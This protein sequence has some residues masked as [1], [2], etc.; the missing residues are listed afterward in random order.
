[1]D[2]RGTTAARAETQ[3]IFE[4]VAKRR[5]DICSRAESLIAGPLQS[6]HPVAIVELAFFRIAQHLI[7]FGGFLKFLLGCIIPRIP[8]WVIL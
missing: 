5:E 1:L 2:T 8:I 6:L 3:E 7:G 4:E